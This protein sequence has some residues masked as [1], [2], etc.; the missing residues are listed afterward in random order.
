MGFDARGAHAHGICF[1][2]SA[3]EWEMSGVTHALMCTGVHLASGAAW[4]VLYYDFMHSAKHM[5]VLF[6]VRGGAPR[7]AAV[8]LHGM[9]STMTS[10]TV[11]NIWASPE[12]LRA[13]SQ[14]GVPLQAL[15]IYQQA[16]LLNAGMDSLEHDLRHG[17][18][19]A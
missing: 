19:G 6:D 1:A 18:L 8:E 2:V 14:L 15:G 10:C 11:Q 9:W 12:E 7:G 3:C 16:S 5:C 4:N 17:Q 13:L